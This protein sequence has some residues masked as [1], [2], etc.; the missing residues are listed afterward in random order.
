MRSSVVSQPRY[1]VP[2]PPDAMMLRNSN[3]RSRIGIMMGLPHLVQGTVASGARSPGMKTFV[4]HQPHVTIR[5]GSLMFIQSNTPPPSDNAFFACQKIV[6]TNA[7]KCCF[8][9]P[10]VKMKT[11][12]AQ[13]LKHAPVNGWMAICQRSARPFG[14]VGM[15]F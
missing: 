13:M 8:L 10:V 2:M 15:K 4:S 7:A 6:L 14:I 12:I 9:S 5:N 11:T 3:C 1:T